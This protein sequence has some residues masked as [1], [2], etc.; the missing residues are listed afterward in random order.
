MNGFIE[1][2]LK[3]YLK[4]FVN[5][6][7]YYRNVYP[8][9]SFDWTTYQAF[10]LP[11]YIPINRHPGLQKYIEELVVDVLGK[12]PHVHRFNLLI[13]TQEDV[14]VERYVLDFGEFIHDTASI[15]VHETQVFD[16]FRSCLNS[17]I[18]KLEKL[19]S[20]GPNKVTF[21]ATLD[22][23]SI[24]LGHSVHAVKTVQ[25]RQMLEQSVNWTKCKADTFANTFETSQEY[26]PKIKVTSMVGCDIGPMVIYQFMERLLPPDSALMQQ[27]QS[28]AFKIYE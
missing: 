12:L 11:R 4:C 26:K 18:S 17:L 9:E 25:G 14:C 8:S 27:S 5:V 22:A 21:S 23:V 13:V 16:E 1:K 6:V 20:I 2:W 15:E 10:N 19:P 28:E 3:I 7:L 24:G